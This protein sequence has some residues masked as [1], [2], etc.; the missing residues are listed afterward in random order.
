[1]PRHTHLVGSVG[2]D[3]VEE[4]F[5]TAGRLLGAR[6]KRI[7]DGEPGG[8]R[9]WTSWQYPVFLGSP[10]L[11]TDE[12]PQ[13]PA[14]GPGMRRIVVAPG[15]R[16]EDI[17]F[18]ELG[19]AR[20]ARASYADFLAA[21][22]RGD[23]AETTRFQVCLPTPINVVTNSCAADAL[24]P[25]EPAYESAVIREVERLCA[26]IPHR[27]LC[28]QWDMVREV[29]WWDG[30]LA[31]S[32]PAPFAD[33]ENET[34]ARLKRIAAAVPREVELGFHLCY[35]DWG[36]RHHID[37]ADTGKMVAFANAIAAALDR[38]IAYFHM[39]VPIARHDSAYFAPLSQLALH[40]DTE[41][42]LGLVHLADGAQGTLRRIAGARAIRE[43]FGIASECGLGRCKTPATVRDIL[44][45]YDQASR[46]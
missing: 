8:R 3:S 39:P 11:A 13:P 6:L 12:R 33:I 14:R 40:G 23:I 9:V 38:P 17:R 32:Q 43:D 27:D 37:P 5:A 46:A 2:L 44:A 4:V 35:G 30:R 16:P 36:G 25:I 41:L 42:F 34:I 26:A 19:Y 24:L 22:K 10:F 45:V 28:L 7:P 21:R 31:A 18:G 29:I 1:M 20:E 15:I